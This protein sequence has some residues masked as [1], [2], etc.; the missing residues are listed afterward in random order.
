MRNLLFDTPWWLLAGLAVVAATLL[1]SGNNRQDKNLKRGGLFFLGLLILLSLL[2]YFVDTDIEKVTKRT[3]LVAK[4]VEK[5]DWPTFES[6]LDPHI[7]LAHYDDRKSLVEGAKATADDI[8]LK[9]ARVTSL[10]AK[11]EDPAA[12]VVDLDALSV[13]DVTMDRPMPTSWRF[14]WIKS[15]DGSWLLTNITPLD[16]GRVTHE[17]ITERLARPR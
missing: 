6:L 2:S 11:Q 14:E 4:S 10:Q 8:G 5:R 13:Q 7:H 9:S 1:V 12:I 15:Q 17:R 16:N 3:K